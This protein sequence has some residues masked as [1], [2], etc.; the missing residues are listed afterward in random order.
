MSIIKRGGIWALK[1][2]TPRRYA[3]VEPRK[4]VWISLKTDS[5][6]EA[7]GKA[8]VVWRG[9]IASWEARLAGDTTDAQRRYEAALNIAAQRGF[10]YLPTQQ[11]AALPANELRG[12]LNALLK[13]PPQ[14]R[15]IEADA[16][17]GTANPSFPTLSEALD[18]YWD[19]SASSIRT[20]SDDQIRQWRN[21]RIKAIKNFIA[22]VGDKRIDQ[23]VPDDMLEFH[24]WW[25]ERLE[26]EGLTA[27]SAN[28][29]LSH[30]KTVLNFVNERKRF[31]LDLP[32]SGYSFKEGEQTERPPFSEEWIR[33][34]F[35]PEGALATLNPEARAIFL[36][37]INTGYRPSE[38]A[39]LKAEHIVLDGPVPHIIITP[40]ARR[41]IKNK[42]SRRMI[43]LTGVSLDAF[44]AFPRGFP[45]YQSSTA[46]L[47]ALVN[48]YLRNNN[49]MESADHVM[50][51]LRHSFEDRMIRAGLDDRVRRDLFGHALDR[52]R[53]GEGGGLKFKHDLLMRI[54]L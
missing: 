1:R 26:L 8:E 50:Y 13:S 28:K 14:V 33:E 47:S 40:E 48:K 7:E 32:L 31:R 4:E 53:Y 29:D 2:R 52:E 17:L 38:G 46:S 54:A 27:N 18:M 12:R 37:M 45:R 23:I 22:V 21:P 41:E 20:K 30:I 11:V 34:K 49:L 25:F 39:S 16:L 24:D 36:G 10:A 35:I 51:S 15:S 42:S 6:S 3:P 9:L 19:L 5:E 43:P 44:R